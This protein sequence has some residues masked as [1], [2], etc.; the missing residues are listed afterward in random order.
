[1]AMVWRFE[2]E[3]D[4][5]ARIVLSIN[6]GK[7]WD[8]LRGHQLEYAVADA[9][10]TWAEDEPGAWDDGDLKAVVVLS[11]KNMAGLYHVSLARTCSAVAYIQHPVDL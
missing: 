11:P 7:T 8:E 4:S 5:D 10:A 9:V 6:G 2:D 3:D 1:M